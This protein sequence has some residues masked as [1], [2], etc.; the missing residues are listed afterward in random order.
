MVGSTVPPVP[1]NCFISQAFNDWESN[2]VDDVMKINMFLNIIYY[3]AM[4]NE[5]S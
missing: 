5:K 4:N 1:F 2:L 3:N